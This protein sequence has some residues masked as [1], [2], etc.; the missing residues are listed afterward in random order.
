M[1]KTI[2]IE[3]FGG[4][5]TDVRNLPD[6]YK[7]SVN[8]LDDGEN[9]NEPPTDPLHKTKSTKKLIGK[10][11]VDAGMVWVGDPCYIL[12]DDDSVEPEI[13]WERLRSSM[14][15]KS[16]ASLNYQLGHEGV[17]VCVSSGHGDGEYSV[18]A[19]IQDGIVHS[20]QVIFIGE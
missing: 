18:Y 2:E 16:H 14:G 12:P 19:D 8:D 15:N 6:G 13:T 20:V 11:G 7:Y 4:L 9:Y 1:K 3:M 10:I 5:V 17:G